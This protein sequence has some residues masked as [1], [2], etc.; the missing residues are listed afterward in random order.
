MKENSLYGDDGGY[1]I[2]VIV[3]ALITIM[4]ILI[5]PMSIEKTR[6]QQQWRS[7]GTHV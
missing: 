2:L 4:I 3:T 7:I 5:L 1:N 6:G